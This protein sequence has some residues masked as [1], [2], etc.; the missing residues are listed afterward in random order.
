MIKCIVCKE[1]KQEFIITDP[2]NK[3]GLCI[4]CYRYFIELQRENIPNKGL[5][6]SYFAFILPVHL[7][8]LKATAE[9][10]RNI[11]LDE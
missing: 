2:F 8:N 7:M 9:A 5:L 3:H 4:D 6:E 1:V 10:I 11:R